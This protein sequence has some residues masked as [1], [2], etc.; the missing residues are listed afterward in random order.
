MSDSNDPISFKPFHSAVNRIPVLRETAQ[1]DSNKGELPPELFSDGQPPSHDHLDPDRWSGSIDLEMT[2]RTPLVF[3]EQKNGHVKL[4]IVGGKPIVP[5]TMVKGMISRA[6]ETL[7]CSRFRVFGDMNNA[8]AFRRD[9]DDRRRRLT[10]RADP[11]SALQLVPLR[12]TGK[13]TDGSLRAVLLR[14]DVLVQG[15]YKEDGITYRTMYAAALQDTANNGHA[16]LVLHGGIERL[17]NLTK[18]EQEIR[19]DMSL[20][21]HNGGRG[22]AR[23]SYW[24]V[25]HIYDTGGR[26]LEAFR[27]R[28]NVRV[29]DTMENKTGYVFRTTAVGDEPNQLFAHKHDERVFFDVS[30][31]PEE[32]VLSNAVCEGYKLVVDSYIREREGD[33][34]HRANRATAEHAT[35]LKCGSLAYAV[36][37]RNTQTGKVAVHEVVPI[38]IGRHAYAASPYSLAKEQGVLPLASAEQSSAADR[39][40]GY[41]V[42]EV[43]EAPQG[44]DVAARGQVIVSAVDTSGALI[45]KEPARLVPLLSPKPNSARRFLT[46]AQGKTPQSQSPSHQ[47]RPLKRSEHFVP[48][49]LLGVAA[50]PVHRDILDAPGMP[51]SATVLPVE[52]GV[53][54]ANDDVRLTADAWVAAGSVLRCRLSFNNV[55]GA[56]LGAL[57][58]VLTPENLVPAGARGSVGYLRMG[59]GKPLGLGVLEVRVAPAGLRVRKNSHFAEQYTALTGCLGCVDPVVDPGEFELPEAS[60]LAKTPWVKAMQR[61]AYGYDDGS[62]VRHMRLKENRENNRIDFETG[63]PKRG[64]GIAPR[65]LFGPES[66]KPLH[67]T[68]HKKNHGGQRN[69]G[70][71]SYRGRRR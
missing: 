22:T 21:L 71:T 5:P 31:H 27:I 2:V 4:P 25:T 6:Y 18:H 28:D 46:D 14:G 47:R 56:E 42:P 61:A 11:A 7:T 55:S 50:Y 32:V 62:P 34:Q 29:V 66:T 49:Q 65:D 33:G 16:Q 43:R 39:L 17:R 44:G 24:Q 12:V 40:F 48:G 3:G 19:C 59:L 68:E 54:Q 30:E 1:T 8:G 53:D 9:V 45:R 38:L 52:D 41:V 64:K 58:W 60:A 26:R 20:C 69:Y 35:E 67:I 13:N 15:D 23:Y 70:R 51:R 10:Y 36:V 63:E 37:H 57:L